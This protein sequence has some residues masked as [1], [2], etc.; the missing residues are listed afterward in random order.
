MEGFSEHHVESKDLALLTSFLKLLSGKPERFLEF[1]LSWLW[2]GIEVIVLLKDG[3][4]GFCR[5]IVVVAL[6]GAPDYYASASVSLMSP[7][8]LG[9]W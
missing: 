2:N 5:G 4:Y 3:G 6:G 7:S 8:N 1:G 9:H